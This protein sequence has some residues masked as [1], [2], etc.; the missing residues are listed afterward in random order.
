[1]LYFRIREVKIFIYTGIFRKD[2]NSEQG[3]CLPAGSLF[4]PELILYCIEL[5]FKS[6]FLDKVH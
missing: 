4:A 1:M 3:T 2:M 5:Y 6:A